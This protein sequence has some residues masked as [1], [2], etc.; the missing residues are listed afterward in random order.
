MG[1]KYITDIKKLKKR[2]KK[3]GLEKSISQT[4]LNYVES[5]ILKVYIENNEIYLEKTE[6]MDILTQS[7]KE[8][9]LGI[10]NFQDHK[11]IV[12]NQ[13]KYKKMRKI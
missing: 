2:L 3:K 10:T 8:V 1:K 7:L 13:L 9:K 6:K 12:E 5:G 4:I 11:K